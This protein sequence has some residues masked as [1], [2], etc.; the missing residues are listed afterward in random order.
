MRNKGKWRRQWRKWQDSIMALLYPQGAS[1]QL[2]G[3]MRMAVEEYALCEKCMQEM[4]GEKVPAGAC[5]RC[6]SPVRRGKK[7][8]MCAS[9]H[10]KD[11]EKCYAPFCYHKTVRKAVH[12]LKFQQNASFLEYLCEKMTDAL[13]DRDF[14]VICPVPLSRQRMEKRGKNQSRL[15]AEGVALRTGIPVSDLLIRTGNQ[16]PQS[17]TPLEKRAMNVKDCFQCVSEEGKGKRILLVDDVRTTGSTAQACAK[18]LKAA[19]AKSVCLCTLAV[20]YRNPK[21][22]RQLKGGA[23]QGSLYMLSH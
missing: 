14:D 19:G 6:L 15:L 21:K 4:E 12:E 11:I 1:C 20:V 16:K 2:C 7:C 5:D 8:A 9:G 23:Y 17:R 10:M 22:F 3:D 18:T 13:I